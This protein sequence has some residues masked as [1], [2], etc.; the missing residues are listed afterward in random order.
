[1]RPNDENGKLAPELRP[2]RVLIIS[3]SQRRQYSCPGVDS[4]SRML[5]LRMA[6]R[7][8][9]DW[10]I[11]Y[12]DLANVHGRMRI[13]PCNGCVSTS[14]A[15]CCWPCNCYEKGNRK[16]PD[17][18]WEL[19]LY[20]RL[21]LADAWAIIGP[22]NWYGPTTNL[23]AMFDRLVSMNGGNPR[24]ALIPRAEPEAKRETHEAIVWQC[25]FSGIEVPDDL[26]HY[27]RFGMGRK[28]SDNQA[29]DMAHDGAFMQGFDAW[30]D[31]FIAFV[32]AKG[33]VPPGKFRA[34]GYEPPSHFGA[35]MKL[36]VR[37]RMLRLGKAPANSSPEAQQREDLNRD[38]HLNP[39][40]GEGARLRK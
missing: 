17:L 7:L 39:K 18:M 24:E 10:E 2:Y 16:E 27:Q 28:Y 5:M 21:D 13:Q 31:R 3:A 36:T 30:A 15:L 12:E 22:V 14:M 8:P 32:R 25:R 6:D 29:E 38:R 40:E 20:A 11:D 1:M 4:K 37:D 23:K 9:Q 33:K 19:D 26:W 35:D 34:Y